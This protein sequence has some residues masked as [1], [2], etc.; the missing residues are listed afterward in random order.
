[1]DETGQ[2][3]L[4][5]VLDTSAL[6]A[7]IED[8][9]GADTVEELFERAERNQ[10]I[11]FVSFVTFTELFYITLREQGDEVACQRMALLERLPLVRVE[12]DPPTGL[13]AGRLKASYSLSLADSWIAALAELY[14]AVLVHKDPEFAALASRVEQI[15]LPYKS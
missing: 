5:Y 4:R 7:Y 10:A 2:V 3:P 11:L 1:M 13:T 15:S 8:E 12:S 9:E 6:L 14:A